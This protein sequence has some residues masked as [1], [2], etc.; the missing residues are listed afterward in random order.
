MELDAEAVKVLI[1]N[2]KGYKD[3]DASNDE[4]FEVMMERLE[5]LHM[6]FD[7]ILL[8]AGEREPLDESEEEDRTLSPYYRPVL[9]L[10]SEGRKPKRSGKK[11]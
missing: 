10:P 2:I 1:E 6:M 9:S 8:Q 11:G 7:D 3:A 4:E 5:A